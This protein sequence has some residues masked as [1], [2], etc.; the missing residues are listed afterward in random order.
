MA[1]ISIDEVIKIFDNAEDDTSAIRMI[2]PFYR[3]RE[4]NLEINKFVVDKMVQHFRNNNK[5]DG[6]YRLGHDLELLLGKNSK[7]LEEPPF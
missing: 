4:A 7:I 5:P 6:T 3:I 2:V 1:D